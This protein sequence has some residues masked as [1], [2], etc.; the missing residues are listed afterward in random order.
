MAALKAASIAGSSIDMYVHTRPRS[1]GFAGAR[2]QPP[3]GVLRL[4]ILQLVHPLGEPDHEGFDGIREGR[5]VGERG[6]DR[7]RPIVHA[8]RIG[9]A[10]VELNARPGR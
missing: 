5:V 1:G 10:P 7:S 3:E 9:V 2:G 6:E 8:A 4:A